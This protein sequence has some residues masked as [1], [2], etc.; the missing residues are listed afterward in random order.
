MIQCDHKV[1]KIDYEDQAKVGVCVVCGRRRLYDSVGMEPPKVI[2]EGLPWDR[3]SYRQKHE[4]YE[5]HREEIIQDYRSVEG[6]RGRD[7][8]VCIKWQILTGTWTGLKKLWGLPITSKFGPKIRG[9]RGG[10]GAE[11]L[12]EHRQAQVPVASSPLAEASALIQVKPKRSYRHGIRLELGEELGGKIAKEAKRYDIPPGYLARIILSQFFEKQDTTKLLH[13]DEIASEHV[14]AR[15]AEDIA[16][17]LAK[18]LT[19]EDND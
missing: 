16:K 11:A 1:E 8:E 13:L 9:K 6:G 10:A 7:K 19:G 15:L 4:Y 5:Q 14:I 18:E 3:I 17:Q 12:E 2:L